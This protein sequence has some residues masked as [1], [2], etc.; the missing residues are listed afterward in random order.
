MGLFVTWNKI[1]GPQCF[2]DVTELT[3]VRVYS[4]FRWKPIETD[5]NRLK[6]IESS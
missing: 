2:T 3:E 1:E 4:N 5:G 6:P